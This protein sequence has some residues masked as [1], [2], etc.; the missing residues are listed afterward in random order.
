MEE[1]D[2]TYMCICTSPLGYDPNL[3]PGCKPLKLVTLSHTHTSPLSRDLRTYH[4]TFLHCCG[5]YHCIKKKLRRRVNTAVLGMP[6]KILR[7]VW[8][9]KNKSFCRGSSTT[10]FIKVAIC[11]PS[12][13]SNGQKGAETHCGTTRVPSAFVI[14]ACLSKHGTRCT[15]GHHQLFSPPQLHV[16]VSTA[17]VSGYQYREL[18]LTSWQF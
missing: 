16:N 6:L 7:P 5:G 12:G 17:S 13:N 10:C 3:V 11:L 4:G 18:N 9:G 8:P 2:H 14:S 15:G 1:H